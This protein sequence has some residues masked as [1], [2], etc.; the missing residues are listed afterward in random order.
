MDW[1]RLYR[2]C[3][4]NYS[5]FFTMDLFVNSFSECIP[6]KKQ[7]PV[8]IIYFILWGAFSAI[9]SLPAPFLFEITLTMSYVIFLIKGNMLYRI[10]TFFKFELY[11]FVCAVVTVFLHTMLTMDSSIFAT[12]TPYASYTNII[13]NFLIYV[14]LATYIIIRKLSS[15]PIGMVFRRY[16]VVTIC[17]VILSL[18]VCNMLFGSTILQQ[19]EVLPAVFSL[20]LL[21]TLFCIFIYR[22][23]IT[24][25]EENTLT[26]IE[27]EK[28]SLE[29]DYYALIEENLNNLSIL[30]HDFKNHLII[31]QGYAS[32]GDFEKLEN[33][34]HCLC[35]SLTSTA[36]IETPSP[37]ISSLMN[38][39]KE[40]CRRK[41]VAL[42]FKHDFQN[43][44]I[45]DYHMITML[46]NLLDNAITAAAKIENGYVILRI[47]DI[48]SSHLE[49]DCTNNHQEKI[50]KKNNTF[51][52]TKNPHTGIHG[53][54]L[55]SVRKTVEAL[56]GEMF[57]DYTDET[58]H[59][60]I[61]VPNY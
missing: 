23:V 38:A 27:L 32:K 50:I 28:V 36:L 39:K 52:S 11:Y 48:H 14:I 31:I 61:I 6:K 40:D 10:G 4:E 60:N 46:S 17:T 54:G 2:D 13:G 44:N 35:E 1:F 5:L 9:P 15:F 37:L 58:F 43:I 24:I 30:R 45:S 29:Q 12:N 55:L 18:I 7:Y 8:K 19:E 53:L 49:I 42:N 26:K 3:L 34:T 16:F 25:L 57:I 56:R 33:Y 20:L 59:V 21:V 41:H 47:T 22:K 51:L